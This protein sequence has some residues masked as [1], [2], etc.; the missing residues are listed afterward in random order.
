MQ[1]LKAAVIAC[2]LVLAAPA[3]AYGNKIHIPKASFPIKTP[4]TDGSMQNIVKK[5][6]NW[7]LDRKR[8]LLIGPNERTFDLKKLNITGP[9]LD[10]KCI[11]GK[12][13]FV[14]EA[15][16]TLITYLNPDSKPNQTS[17]LAYSIAFKKDKPK[18]V[19][20]INDHEMIGVFES[21]ELARASFDSKGSLSW[22]VCDSFKEELKNE[23][24]SILVSYNESVF[25]VVL[26]TQQ[27][28]LLIKLTATVLE[29]EMIAL[30]A[31]FDENAIG[32]QTKN[33]FSIEF[34]NGTMQNIK[35]PA[36]WLE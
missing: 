4:V 24:Q 23:Q 22:A 32:I 14:T 26:P 36:K 11:N 29:K 30:D 25:L 10:Y 1:R 2:F 17:M 9:I 5:Q 35:V 16:F 8:K 6:D 28:A 27:K 18:T 15:G 12:H 21:G 13:L 31:A 33:G 34:G 19:A 20:I 7:T 3:T